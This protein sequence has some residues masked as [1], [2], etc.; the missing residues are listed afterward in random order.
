MWKILSRQS[1][2]GSFDPYKEV[3]KKQNEIALQ[4]E[5]I[6]S[7][8]IAEMSDSLKTAMVFSAAGNAIDL[9]PNCPIPDIYKRYMEIISKGF[10]W[11][12]YEL[13]LKKLAR[14]KSLLYLGDNAGEIVWDKIL[15]EELVD[16]FDLDI[17]Y[18]VRGFPILNDATME[19]AL[20]VGMDKVVNVISNGSDA[21]GTILNRC[22]EEFLNKYQK[23]DLILSKG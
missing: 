18:A 21:P 11:D 12:D 3:K 2:T 8:Q 15:I 13:F 6:L 10:A 19:D 9:A 17:T 23:S 22:S 20:F 5:S 4:Y 1:I 16:T 14:S 7:S